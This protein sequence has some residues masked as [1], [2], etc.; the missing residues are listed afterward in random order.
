MVSA[1]EFRQE[2]KERAIALATWLSWCSNEPVASTLK[3]ILLPYS[4]ER[5]VGAL[6]LGDIA[7]R[8][9]DLM[10]LKAS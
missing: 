2:H 8:I 10:Q 7:T 6:I 9:K 1:H 5:R 3:R 4:I